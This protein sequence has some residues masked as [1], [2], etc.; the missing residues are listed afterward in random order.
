MRTLGE[1]INSAKLNEEVSN[2]ELLYAVC[3]M[4]ALM[5]FDSM[6]LMKLAEGEREGKK[7]IL[8][9]NP[10]WQHTESFARMKRALDKSPK[11]FVGWNN[12]PK[13]PEV[14]ENRKKAIAFANKFFS[15]EE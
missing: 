15:K 14:V 10:I 8:T 9:F 5:T 6:A 13:N 7:K 4:D 11:E 2:E 3:A 12:D 1:I